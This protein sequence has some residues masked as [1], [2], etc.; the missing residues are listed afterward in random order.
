MIAERYI[1]RA[2]ALGIVALTGLGVAASFA[3]GHIWLA[4]DLVAAERIMDCAAVGIVVVGAALIVALWALRRWH[5]GSEDQR[6]EQLRQRLTESLLEER[7]QALRQQAAVEQVRHSLEEQ[8]R[9]AQRM[10]P[11]AQLAGGVGH[12]LN[13]L[14]A[15]VQGHTDMLL[16][17]LPEENPSRQNAEMIQKALGRSTT[18]VRQMLNLSRRQEPTL[19]VL[20]LNAM[21]SDME[22]MLSPIIGRHIHVVTHLDAALGQIKADAGQVDQIILNLAVNARDAMPNGGQLIIE[23]ANVELDKSYARMHADVPPGPYV[24]LVVSDTGVG[25]TEEVQS[26]IFEPL[27][28]TKGPGKGT[29]LGLSTVLGIVKQSRGHIKVFSIP[30]KGSTFRIYFP[31]LAEAAAV[32]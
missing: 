16:Q 8:L 20:D 6:I 13:N 31:R 23:T 7:E 29:G 28:S 19:R 3:I 4:N 14:L 5:K 10:E 11:I 21:V 24:M 17:Q 30:G 18:L 27:F 1:G 22:K 26:H 32:P 12:D 2:L 25:M 9:Q 15:V